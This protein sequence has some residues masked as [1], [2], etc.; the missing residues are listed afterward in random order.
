MDREKKEVR[1][2]FDIKNSHEPLLVNSLTKSLPYDF[3]LTARDYVEV[4]G[5][6][7][8]YGLDF[9][10]VGRY[11]GKNDMGRA[12]YIG[13]RAL[14]LFFR[15]PKYDFLLSHG[16]LYAI[17]ASKARLKPSI[18][19]FD[20]DI[21][22]QILKEIFKRS[23]YLILTPYT[24]YRKFGVDKNKV[25]I[26]DG[27][28]EDIYLAD[29]KPEECKKEIPFDNYILIRPE[30]YNAYYVSEKTSLVPELIKRFSRENY[31]IVL[32]PRYPEE[33]QKYMKYKNIFIPEK[34]VNGICA[35]WFADAVLTGSGTLGRE[36]A[37]MG[38]KSVSFFPGKEMLSVDTELINRGWLYHSRDPEAIV[39]YVMNTPKRKKSVDRSKKVKDEVVN[40]I[41]EIIDV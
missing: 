25:H 36:A 40:I 18:T 5:L 1:V 26:F 4:V 15:V 41:R 11:H 3:Y 14:E 19:I 32:L 38:T 27:F 35:A 39:D 30:A 12:M 34:P 17:Y 16:S 24:N 29:L 28:K 22:G 7:E 23:T 21:S 31:N 10:V 37:C 2:W 13:I 8:K 9:K 6:L 20:G 33:R